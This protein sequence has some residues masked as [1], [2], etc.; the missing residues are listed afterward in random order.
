MKSTPRK[1]ER[2]DDP[3]SFNSYLPEEAT[4]KE[5][6]ILEIS[7]VKVNEAGTRANYR[8]HLFGKGHRMDEGAL[9]WLRTNST[10]GIWCWPVS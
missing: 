10:P 8:W 4:D 7:N 3:C 6:G 2:R 1:R 9:H 5:M